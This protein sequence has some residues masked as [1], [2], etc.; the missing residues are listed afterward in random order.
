MMILN[1]E[2]H[3]AL[4]KFSRGA[5]LLC[6]MLVIACGG[7]GQ[8][9]QTQMNWIEGNGT[10]EVFFFNCG[11]ADSVLVRQGEHA[12]L[13]DAATDREAPYVV[14]RLLEEGVRRLDALLITHEHR[15]HAGG[16]SEV[17]RRLEVERVYMG[18]LVEDGNKQTGLLTLAMQKKSMQPS[19]LV[20]GDAF[21]LGLAQVT[22]LGPADCE[23][24]SANNAS[25]VVRIDF[26]QTRFLFAAD[27]ENRALK[28][29]LSASGGMQNLRAQVLKVPYHGRALSRSAAFFEAV[30]PEIAVITCQ[31]DPWDELPDASTMYM[32]EHIGAGIYVTGDGEVKVASDG[33]EL[34]VTVEGPRE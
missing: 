24:R 22:V 30:R 20:A 31:R 29:L 5:A 15:D 2:V 34:V 9:V 16:A 18:P 19:P 11:K 26:G 6:A 1:R 33:T 32:L 3:M 17:L 23:D 14:S 4:K 25:I 7:I 13:I 21:W 12:M 28:E 10:L 27:A 8:A